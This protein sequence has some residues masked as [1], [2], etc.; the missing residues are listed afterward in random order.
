M[1]QKTYKTAVVLIPPDNTWPAIQAIREKYDCHVHRWMPHITLLYP[2]RPKEQFE[3]ILPFFQ[4]ALK[5]T[6]PFSLT[7]QNFRFFTQRRGYTLWLKP[8]PT[9]PLETL[10]SSLQQCT[11][12]CDDV[13]K[14]KNG[15]TPHLTLGQFPKHESMEERMTSFQE[16]WLPMHFQVKSVHLLWREDPPNDRFQI[17]HTLS[18]G[19][20]E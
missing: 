5:E 15:F 3:L 6:A 8:K 12:D 20:D 11:P 4:A 18:L 10:Q 13:H 16:D 14:H 2:F 9:Q 17:A 1:S 7:L 19:D